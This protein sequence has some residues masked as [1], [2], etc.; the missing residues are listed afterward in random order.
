MRTRRKKPRPKE[1]MGMEPMLT[2]TDWFLAGNG[3]MGVF[4]T[5]LGDLKGPS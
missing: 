1:V 4:G 2:K 5:T 3:G